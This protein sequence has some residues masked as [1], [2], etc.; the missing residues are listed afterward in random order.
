MSY[1]SRQT[2]GSQHPWERNRKASF[3]RLTCALEPQVKNRGLPEPTGIRLSTNQY[4]RY[5][6]HSKPYRRS[7][8]G[9]V[10]RWSAFVSSYGCYHHVWMTKH[11]S[12]P[13][14]RIQLLDQNANCCWH[15]RGVCWHDDLYRA[16]RTRKKPSPIL[17][18]Q[19]RL[20]RREKSYRNTSLL[21]S[22]L[23]CHVPTECLCKTSGNATLLR[24]QRLLPG[25]ECHA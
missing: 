17:G 4:G 1:P 2:R 21:K 7:S 19:Y 13:S 11:G 25:E 8:I 10:R 5:Y 14:S 24:S 6:S 3:T 15:S 20:C 22:Q 16:C 12:R 18:Q 23:L 9:H